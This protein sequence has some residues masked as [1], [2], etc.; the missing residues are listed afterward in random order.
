LWVHRDH[1]AIIAKSLRYRGCS[2]IGAV[3]PVAQK[4]TAREIPRRVAGV[5]AA[6]DDE[7]RKSGPKMGLF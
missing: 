2:R 7:S 6:E 5:I 1:H 3:R 4:Q